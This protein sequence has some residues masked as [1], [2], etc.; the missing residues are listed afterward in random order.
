MLGRA[1]EG[2]RKT[3]HR[4]VEKMRDHSL[5]TGQMVQAILTLLDVLHCGC[6]YVNISRMQSHQMRAKNPSRMRTS[7]A[8]PYADHSHTV[9]A[10]CENSF[11]TQHIPDSA[12]SVHESCHG[13]RWRSESGRHPI[14]NG[15]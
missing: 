13:E 3:I 14:S 2:T 10:P 6:S 11:L 4:S 1:T 8:F 5:Q 12:D 9:I 7:S 15:A